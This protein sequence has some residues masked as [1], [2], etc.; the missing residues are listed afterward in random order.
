MYV[1]V[2]GTVITPG[3]IAYNPT[4]TVL[5]YIAKAGITVN[6]GSADRVVILD[7]MGQSRQ[8][9]ARKE[10]PKPGDHILVPRSFE[11]KTRDY[12]G[13]TAAVS[14]LAV[15]IATFLVLLNQ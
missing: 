2:G 14:S 9:N 15:A 4:F 10:A 8:V 5:D 6:T 3:A 7:A 11:A 12:V 13:L 1:F